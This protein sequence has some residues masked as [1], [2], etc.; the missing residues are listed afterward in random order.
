MSVFLWYNITIIQKERSV[1][2]EEKILELLKEGLT[3]NEIS[4]K[5]NI[6]RS[7]VKKIGV[8]N[9]VIIMPRNEMY[10]KGYSYWKNGYSLTE[11]QEKIK[12]SRQWLSLY[13]KQRDETI[14]NPTK[15]YF[16]NK[17]VF[18]KIDVEEKAYWLGFI[19]ADGCINDTKKSKNLEITLCSKDENHLIK[20][21]KF[22]GLT[23]E[24]IK[25]KKCYLKETDKTYDA[26]RVSVYNTK[27]CNDLIKLGVTPR[28]SEIIKFNKNINS[29]LKYH[30][31]RGYIDG[32]GYFRKISRNS[33]ELAIVSSINFIKG[34]IEFTNIEKY[35][36]YNASKSGNVKK[37]HV[38]G[39]DAFRILEKSYLNSNIYL[40]RK[41]NKAIAVLD[42]NV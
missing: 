14:T 28:K 1:I 10:E 30:Y 26:I 34:F 12:I 23:S 19:S 33:C 15:K 27:I 41:Y 5:L 42:R 4:R 17:N 35:K 9:N 16:Y 24:R 29:E 2:V 40:D 39:K 37:L 8:K 36:I 20:F 38:S 31:I 25:H 3:Q 22:I 7:Y 18:E 11:I 32:N 13:I 6:S 21:C